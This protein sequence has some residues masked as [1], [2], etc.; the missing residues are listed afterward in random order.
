MSSRS[1]LS[2]QPS[3]HPQK[4]R[5]VAPPK[6]VHQIQTPTN[7]PGVP[8]VNCYLIEDPLTL[9]D[10]GLNTPPAWKAFVEQLEQ[11]GY[12]PEQIE[13][14]LIT[15]AHPDHFG[16]AERLRSISNA[17]VYLS[18]H[19]RES[20]A[21]NET[22]IVA[23]RRPVYREFFVRL[24]LDDR[25]FAQLAMMGEF[26]RAIA[27]HIQTRP[28]LLR[29]G[30]TIPFKDFD[31]EVLYTPGHTRDIVCYHAPKGGFIFSSD[32]LLQETSPNPVVD[33]GPEGEKDFSRKFRSLVSY[34]EQIERVRNLELS[35]VLPGHGLPFE[36][37][38]AVI[39]SL[40]YFYGKRQDKIYETLLETGPANVRA[41]TERLFPKAFG[42]Q[43][44]LASCEL[45][46]N[47]EVMEEDGRIRQEFDGTQYLFDLS[48]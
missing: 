12:R 35:C 28:H 22:D 21:L 48:T 5:K 2:I 43:H 24:G 42:M 19:A 46:G 47:L 20:A 27:P 26:M 15:H 8:T 6:G 11:I 13:R 16:F 41:L 33:L 31:L 4:A 32:H 1:D 38:G 37:H 44:F 45:L 29:E 25:I 30:D 14:I 9:V 10:C 36:G 23:Q 34:Y 17:E 7:F 18:E 3:V 40:L 39:N